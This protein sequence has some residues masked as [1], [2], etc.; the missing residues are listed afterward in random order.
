MDFEIAVCDD[1]LFS[2]QNK[3]I[4]AEIFRRE[5]TFCFNRLDET[6]QRQHFLLNI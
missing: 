1:G 6:G 3:R 5:R 2:G 4:A